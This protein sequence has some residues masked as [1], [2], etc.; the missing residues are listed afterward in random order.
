MFGMRVEQWE[1]T[2]DFHSQLKIKQIEPFRVI[3]HGI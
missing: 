2:I 3:N 1:A